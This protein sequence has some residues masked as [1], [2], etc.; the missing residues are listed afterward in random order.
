MLKTVTITLV[1][2]GLN[3]IIVDAALCPQDNTIFN[4]DIGFIGAASWY[5]ESDPCILP[6]TANKE[7]FSD[8]ELTCAAWGLP[9][10]TYLRV[11]NA[12][13]GKSVIVRVNDR[14]PARRLF[15]KGRII[16]LTKTAFARI[17]SLDKGV[18]S[19]KIT[20]LL[21]P[22]GSYRLF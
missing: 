7:Y 10:D 21:L 20:V 4:E 6:M 11:T 19:V 17:E 1:A 14:G 13:N 8:K 18:A 9:F 3:F 22:R 12:R 15:N 5:S 16:D 2:L